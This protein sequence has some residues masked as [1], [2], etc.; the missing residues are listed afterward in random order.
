MAIVDYY[1]TAKIEALITDEG[2]IITILMVR[3]ESS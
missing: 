2:I 3:D 1:R